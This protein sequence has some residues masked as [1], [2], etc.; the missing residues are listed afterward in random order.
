MPQGTCAI[1]MVGLGV[2]GRNL[3]LNI[4][5]HGFPCAGTD[6]DAEK[7][8]LLRQ[9]AAGKP[10]TACRTAAELVAALKPPR[11]IMLLVPAGKA[12]DGA[13]ASLL[14]P[15]WPATPASFPESRAAAASSDT[16]G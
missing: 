16:A 9:E 13:I 15:T 2:M 10:V 1:G 14:P 3:L 4:A 7:V 11:S 6:L 12:V 8:A 5:D